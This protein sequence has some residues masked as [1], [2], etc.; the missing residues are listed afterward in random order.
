MRKCLM[1]VR[2][3][4]VMS[5]VLILRILRCIHIAGPLKSRLF[6][7]NVD[8]SENRGFSPQIIHFRRVFHYKQPSIL[9][10]PY[11]WKHPC[12]G[13][14]GISTDALRLRHRSSLQNAPWQ[15]SA[16]ERD[17][18][19]S[20]VS[21]TAEQRVFCQVCHK[22]MV[23]HSQNFLD[24][25][26]VDVEKGTLSAMVQ[27]NIFLK[28]E[29]FLLFGDTPIF[30]WLPHGSVGGFMVGKKKSPP[31]DSGRTS[32]WTRGQCLQCGEQ[33]MDAWTLL[34]WLRWDFFWCTPNLSCVCL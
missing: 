32:G 10:H 30:H 23:H 28:F 16:V 18:R 13:H 6:S 12:V 20:H 31:N 2:G 25:F 27:W 9:G 17:D 3:P 4:R 33:R 19:T 26:F 34:D 7:W 8:V 29:R 5:N 22:V 11:F 14:F 15:P 24:S 21:F 1:R